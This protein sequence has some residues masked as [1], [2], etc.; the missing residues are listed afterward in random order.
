MIRFFDIVFSLF[1]LI[2]FFPFL[3]ILILFG[4]LDTGSPFFI[5]SRVGKNKA[6]FKLI[7]FRSMKI[8][9]HSV[10]TH[11]VSSYDVTEWGKFLRKTKLDELPQLINV[12]IGDMSFVGPRPNLFNQLEL[13]EDREKKGVYVIR[14]GITGLAQINKIDMSTPRLLAETDAKMVAELNILHYFKYIILTVLGRGFG[15]RVK[16]N[17]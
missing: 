11:L 15:D 6:N 7:K 16:Y 3:L 17:Q 12:L 4:F 5:Q 8:G 13:I 10:S 14:P 2:V 9:T 1:G